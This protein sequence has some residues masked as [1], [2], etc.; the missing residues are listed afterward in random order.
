[1]PLTKITAAEETKIIANLNTLTNNKATDSLNN[2][3]DGK[4][5][6]FLDDNLLM[7]KAY[8]QMLTRDGYNLLIG[9]SGAG[10]NAK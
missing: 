7:R 2:L 8:D 1:M 5:L 4:Y 3:V 10:G 6:Q 9:A